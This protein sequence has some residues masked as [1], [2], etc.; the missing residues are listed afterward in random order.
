[1]RFVGIIG[2]GGP[3]APEEAA[4]ARTTAVQAGFTVKYDTERVTAFGSEPASIAV[5]EH[6]IVF[7]TLYRRADMAKVTTLSDKDRCRVSR[8]RGG[9]LLDA[10]WGDYVAVIARPDGCDVVRA[11][12]GGL[13]VCLGQ[14]GGSLFFASDIALLADCGCDV[15]TI[16]WSE[17]ARHL[18]AG[19]IRRSRTC[20]L[21]VAELR[22][23]SRLTIDGG[24]Y[25]ITPE[26]TPWAAAAQAR[27]IDKGDGAVGQIAPTLLA[28]VA[29]QVAD[30]R[31]PLLLLSGG[32]DSSILA[33]ALHE[34]GSD[35]AA[36][37]FV[38]PEPAG[39]ERAYAHLVA[40]RFG[41]ALV[42]AERDL[43]QV[44]IARSAAAGLPRPARRSFHQDSD[45][46][47][48]RAAA[49]LG[50]DLVIEGGGG[51]NVFCSLQSV[52]PVADLMRSREP[53]RLVLA[54]ARDIAELTDATMLTVLRRAWY[55]AWIRPDA[56]RLPLDR[57]FLTPAAAA[58]AVDAASHPW[59][60]APPR[61][62]AGTAA[63][64]GMLVAAQGW[65]ESFDPRA[66]FDTRCPLLAQPI[67]EACLAVPSW[68]WFHRGQN[69]VV[70]REAFRGRLPDRIID[71][72]SKA[73]PDSFVTR[74]YERNRSRLKD[75]L[76]DG[77]LVAN[78]IV[79]RI[80]LAQVLGDAGPPRSNDH[81]RV[82]RIA[83]AEAWA[84]ARSATP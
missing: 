18:A 82:M 77:L 26:W 37:T 4:Q 71:R 58:T 74:L 47:I 44:D 40:N 10:F 19:D 21:K 27:A 15:H 70:A 41:I 9:V 6:G 3:P 62:W 12:F 43:D 78:G 5:G 34:A 22:G 80:A 55:R 49:A 81:R 7:G 36:L 39:D 8:S 76:L 38:T 25:A 66:D 2:L 23:G 56:L 31:R 83:D 59:F 63:H 35:F 75:F 32:L 50:T 29:A 84:R 48:R 28:A 54:G 20:L 65:V 64:I 61:A 57:S 24:H 60:A 53:W 17:L 79:D 33:C 46:L 14:K 52:A 72:R 68:R 67:V 73:T 45:A 30:A 42:E 16:D 1:M 51:D 69:R 11:P 13:P